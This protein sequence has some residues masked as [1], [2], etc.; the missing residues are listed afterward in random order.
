MNKKIKK[1]S[2]YMLRL[3]LFGSLIACTGGNG[4]V[5]SDNKN[6]TADD[7]ISAHTVELTETQMRNAGI[8]TG[9][10]E[11]KASA[12]SITANGLVVMPPESRH[13]VGFPM[14]GY[15][16]NITLVTGSTVKKGAVMATLEDMA[17]IQL[18]EDYLLA[19]S[20]LVAAQAD[21]DR[22]KLLNNTQSA[23]DKV[24]QQA[25]AVFEN[26]RVLVASQAE[27]LR[28]IGID[29]TGLNETNITRTVALKSPINGIVSKILAN[30]GKYA[31]PE[32]VL[33]EVV[34]PSTVYLSLTVYEKDARLLKAGQRVWCYA[35]TDSDKPYEATVEVVNRSVNENRAVEVW[36]SFTSSQALLMPGTF[37]TAKIQVSDQEAQV[38]PE[39]AVVRWQNQHYI[40]SVAGPRRFSMQPVELGDAAD[41]Y[42]QVRSTLP[43]Q[44]IVLKNAYS[45]LMMLKNSD[46]G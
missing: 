22:Q 26:E 28:L 9:K 24:F 37:V 10:A 46:E 3:I 5:E 2:A 36:C 16:R 32:D 25:S 13:T 7:T 14:G 35:N 6:V 44:H 34:D 18:Q 12:V 27:K 8:E 30:P 31:A 38:L 45:L 21:Y 29:P 43:E 4:S 15:L 17:F 11:Q 1:I 19:K 23:S 39:E 33:F 20:R 42:V 40:F 41:G